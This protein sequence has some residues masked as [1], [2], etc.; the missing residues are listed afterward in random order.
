MFF[1]TSVIIN[2]VMLSV[3]ILSAIMPNVVAP[4]LWYR[5]HVFQYIFNDWTFGRV[6]TMPFTC[7][8]NQVLMLKKSFIINDCYCFVMASISSQMYFLRVCLSVPE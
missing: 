7:R 8:F 6:R 3:I 4:V 1:M 5:P 2:S